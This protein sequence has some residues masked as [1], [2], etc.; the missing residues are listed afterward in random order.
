MGRGAEPGP[1]WILSR[2]VMQSEFQ[3]E[4]EQVFGEAGES[5]KKPQG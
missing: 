4:S 5:V 1:A 3:S 2:G